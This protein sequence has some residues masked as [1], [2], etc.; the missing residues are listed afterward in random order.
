[1]GPRS[2]ALGAALLRDGRDAREGRAVR[3]ALLTDPPHQAVKVVAVRPPADGAE[4]GS[5]GPSLGLLQK[6]GINQRREIGLVAEEE[7]WRGASGPTEGGAAIPRLFW[8]GG[9]VIPAVLEIQDAAAAA[10]VPGQAEKKQND[11][12]GKEP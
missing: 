3:G 11:K 4:T 7:R 1:M 5:R 2:L 8:P 6:I 12:S 9:A 10:V